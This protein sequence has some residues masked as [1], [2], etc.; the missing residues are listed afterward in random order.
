MRQGISK[1]LLAGLLVVQLC[2]PSASFLYAAENHLAPDSSIDLPEVRLATALESVFKRIEPAR[3][4]IPSPAQAPISLEEILED[5]RWSEWRSL[6]DAMSAYSEESRLA[7]YYDRDREVIL[8]HDRKDPDALLFELSDTAIRPEADPFAAGKVV[9]RDKIGRN[10]GLRVFQKSQLFKLK[11]EKVAKYLDRDANKSLM[12]VVDYKRNEAEIQAAK[13]YREGRSF[14][15]PIPA[16]SRPSVEEDVQMMGTMSIVDQ[17]RHKVRSFLR[18]LRGKAKKATMVGGMSTRMPLKWSAMPDEVRPMIESLVRNFWGS[19]ITL[20]SKG[21]VPIGE[22]VPRG[23]TESRVVTYLDFFMT[24]MQRFEEQLREWA[25]KLR[26]EYNGPN[27]VVMLANDE[28]IGQIHAELKKRGNYDLPDLKIPLQE[29]RSQFHAT[30]ADVEAFLKAKGKDL[31]TQIKER[32]RERARR[33]QAHVEQGNWEAA[34]VQFDDTATGHAEFLHQMVGS[35]ELLADIRRGISLYSLRN[36]DNL[37][38]VEDDKTMIIEDYMMENGLDFLGEMVPSVDQSGGVLVMQPD[39]HL[40]LVEQPA[41]EATWKQYLKDVAGEYEH[42]EIKSKKDE[43]KRD[44]YI[45][46]ARE[47][48]FRLFEQ[49]KGAVPLLDYPI[50]PQKGV[51]VDN[52]DQLLKEVVEGGVEEGRLQILR[53]KKDGSYHLVHKVSSRESRWFNPAVGYFTPRYAL[54]IYGKEV[55]FEQDGAM[56]KRWQTWDEFVAE[57]NEAS[58]TPDGLELIAQRGR[59]RFPTIM[60]GKPDRDV[61]GV[62]IKKETNVWES[63]RVALEHGAKVGFIGTLGASSVRPAE[64]EKLPPHER[65]N[66]RFA[67]A[68]TWEGAESWLGNQVYTQDKMERV[69]RG[70]LVHMDVLHLIETVP[71]DQRFETA[72]QLF[73]IALSEGITPFQEDWL[74]L[75]DILR[76]HLSDSALEVVYDKN[77]R[78]ITV[79]EPNNL[80]MASQFRFREAQAHATDRLMETTRNRWAPWTEHRRIGEFTNYYLIG[81]DVLP[82]PDFLPMAHSIMGENRREFVEA[83]PYSPAGPPAATGGN[84]LLLQT[85]LRDFVNPQKRSLDAAGHIAGALSTLPKDADL[86]WMK[87]V[88][89]RYVLIP[90]PHNEYLPV[91]LLGVA[92]GLERMSKDQRKMFFTALEDMLSADPASARLPIAQLSGQAR[93][94][95]SDGNSVLVQTHSGFAGFGYRGENGK[96]S[97]E[98]IEHILSPDAAA[99]ETKTIY[100]SSDPSASKEARVLGYLAEF[101]LAGNPDIGAYSALRPHLEAFIDPENRSLKAADYIASALAKAPAGTPEDMAAAMEDILKANVFLDNGRPEYL[102]VILLG[103]AQGFSLMTMEQK[104]AFHKALSDIKANTPVAAASPLMELLER[105][106]VSSAGGSQVIVDTKIPQSAP[107]RMELPSDIVRFLQGPGAASSDAQVFPAGAALESNVLTFLARSMLAREMAEKEWAAKIRKFVRERIKDYLTPVSAEERDYAQLQKWL[108]G[109]A[110]GLAHVLARDA[111]SKAATQSELHRFLEIALRNQVGGWYGMVAAENAEP[112]RRRLELNLAKI[113]ADVV[114]LRSDTPMAWNAAKADKPSPSETDPRVAQLRGELDVFARDKS[115]EGARTVATAL[116]G[117]KNPAQMQEM[118]REFVLTPGGN[119]AYWPVL[120]RGLVDA[121]KAKNT[122]ELFFQSLLGVPGK[123]ISKMDTMFLPMGQ[124]QLYHLL[125]LVRQ[126]AQAGSDVTVLPSME[127]PRLVFTRDGQE[128]MLLLP[129]LTD[130]Q[131]IS[132]PLRVHYPEKRILKGDGMETRILEALEET[133][134]DQTLYDKTR[135]LMQPVLDRLSADYIREGSSPSADIKGDM[136]LA[137]FMERGNMAAILM[138]ESQSRP[139]R[140]EMLVQLLNAALAHHERHGN[141]AGYLKTGE[142][143][144][145]LLRIAAPDK[146]PDAG[147]P[148]GVAGGNWMRFKQ[149]LAAG[150]ME[151]AAY[152]AGMIKSAKISEADAQMDSPDVVGVK[153]RTYMGM[154]VRQYVLAPAVDKG[155]MPV[156]VAGVA[157]ALREADEATRDL[158]FETLE[159]MDGGMLPEGQKPLYQLLMQ[160]REAAQARDKVN[161]VLDTNAATAEMRVTFKDRE[162]RKALGTAIVR[163]FA[164]AQESNVR[165]AEI[166][167]SHANEA[168]MLTFLSASMLRKLEA[169]AEGSFAKY[170]TQ[171]SNRNN[172]IATP[173]DFALVAQNLNL[174]ADGRLET[175][176]WSG[177]GIKKILDGLAAGKKLPVFGEYAADVMKA[178]FAAGEGLSDADL[179]KIQFIE[180]GDMDDMYD[181]LEKAG[182]KDAPVEQVRWLVSAKNFLLMDIRDSEYRYLVGESG[183]PLLKM[184]TFIMEIADLTDMASY[185]ALINKWTGKALSAA[186]LQD[187]GLMPSPGNPFYI[188]PS[189]ETSGMTQEINALQISTV[190]KRSA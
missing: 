23:A 33:I 67:A 74:K 144:A 129:G 59:G 3:K 90:D 154:A 64:Y 101:M 108:Q 123:N 27:G 98:I 28:N 11:D 12:P 126:A 20:K 15:T 159:G 171:V 165:A 134:R 141:L 178:A 89:S 65:D 155:N 24:N 16:G 97:P 10:F 26:R 51:V 100:F 96:F 116:A 76:E 172:L 163:H 8:I 29:L 188:P 156:V 153:N 148:P 53:S 14:T 47:I 54:Y 170:Y 6:R 81:P 180:V 57:M 61:S 109:K 42:V 13:D 55:E 94:A 113:A 80:T 176:Q 118:I 31:D 135:K 72:L 149:L 131:G 139:R 186:E 30:L 166:P 136:E 189:R 9:A 175:F 125:N 25:V 92:R 22:I 1:R 150:S 39:G 19:V 66:M 158:F 177:R 50:D 161:V 147:G 91:I 110:H 84:V 133:L 60:D 102:P 32:M 181:V 132:I 18:L 111:G 82:A 79:Y 37:S 145:D 121:L 130:I 179:K 143:A 56:Q 152:I 105:L 45:A 174:D 7:V 43:P 106:R 5:S 128:Q 62:V 115:M 117:A 44:E 95:L 85:Q 87:T 164:D 162:D 127:Q 46:K 151:A 2:F 173:L 73:S 183:V 169:Q 52:L 68:K 187:A 137:V 71:V 21:S 138:D 160:V 63:N 40:A 182:L 93:E 4:H 88:I 38:K 75:R 49:H 69:Y 70:Q 184:M 103:V 168:E 190:V 120:F 185:Q 17:Y 140:L 122:Q 142:L 112:A 34:I 99:P 83:Y 41:F 146:A 124:T 157:Q 104:A 107:G 77:S 58:K 78:S 48:A 167:A 86:Q 36:I 119:K 35:G 114:A